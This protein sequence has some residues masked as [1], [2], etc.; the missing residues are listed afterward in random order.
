MPERIPSW[1]RPF[2]RHVK[3]AGLSG[4]PNVVPGPLITMGRFQ[5]DPQEPVD[6]RKFKKLV[7][8]LP[9]GEGPGALRALV[10]NDPDWVPLARLGDYWRVALYATTSL[11]TGN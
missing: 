6:I 5:V 2:V 4:H 1:I 11:P 8:K 9:V 3:P 7:G 10:L